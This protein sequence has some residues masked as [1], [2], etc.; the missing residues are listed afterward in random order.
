MHKP[1]AEF[2]STKITLNQNMVCTHSFANGINIS[3]YESVSF[4]KIYQCTMS[5]G[6]RETLF[7]AKGDYWGTGTTVE[8]PISDLKNRSPV[9]GL[10]GDGDYCRSTDFG[11]EG[12]I[13]C[14]LET[15]IIEDP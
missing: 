1:D 2:H 6:N 4:S 10:L 11:S 5:V 7:V 12:P 14:F 3:N 15:I 8:L 9:G 13:T